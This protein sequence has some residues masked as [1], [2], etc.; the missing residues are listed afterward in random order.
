MRATIVEVDGINIR[1]T[2]QLEQFPN[3]LHAPLVGSG[4]SVATDDL[5]ATLRGPELEQWTLDAGRIHHLNVPA[6]PTQQFG[7][8]HSHA[9][10]SADSRAIGA[11]DQDPAGTLSPAHCAAC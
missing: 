7:E 10:H 11:E 4:P 8:A 5:K 3:A 9:R 2:D 6:A 1:V